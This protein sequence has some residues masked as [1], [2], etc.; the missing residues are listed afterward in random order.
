MMQPGTDL[1]SVQLRMVCLRQPSVMTSQL[2][3]SSF[4]YTL[5]RVFRLRERQDLMLAEVLHL[6][7]SKPILEG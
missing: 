2:G 1:P 7:P 4:F 5:Q 6:I 3:V